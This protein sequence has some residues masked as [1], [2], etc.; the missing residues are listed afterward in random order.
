MGEG[1]VV[2]AISATAEPHSFT[3][4]AQRVC[5]PY[6]EEPLQGLWKYA[7]CWPD[8][9]ERMI[10]RVPGAAT[11]AR[12]SRGPLYG[13]GDRSMLDPTV[14]PK[15]EVN[16]ALALWPPAEQKIIRER[17]NEEIRNHHRKSR[18]LIPLDGT[19]ETGVT[20]QYLY[21]LAR[22]GDFKERRGPTFGGKN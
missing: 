13:F 11:A 3:R 4:R 16:R 12:Y 7:V 15:E 2:E 17:I 10:G 9:W 19:T 6:G 20:W 18:E 14:D 1:E 5:P 21:M 22:R 8:L